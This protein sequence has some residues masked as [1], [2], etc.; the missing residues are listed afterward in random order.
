MRT[1]RRQVPIQGLKL[2]VSIVTTEEMR[3]KRAARQPAEDPAPYLNFFRFVVGGM[4]SASRYL[5]TVRLAT[6]VPSSFLRMS[7]IF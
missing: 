6:M 5:V 1:S 2:Y 4:F 7:A 3:R